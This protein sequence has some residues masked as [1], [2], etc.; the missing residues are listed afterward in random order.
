MFCPTCGSMIDDDAKFCPFCGQVMSG[1]GNPTVVNDD[2]SWGAPNPPADGTTEVTG[3]W[4]SNAAPAPTPAPVPVA[5]PA[6]APAPMPAP[7]PQQR[8]SSGWSNTPAPQPQPAP[9]SQRRASSTRS[10]SG[11]KKIIVGV[12]AALLVAALGTL[13]YFTFFTNAFLGKD[14]LVGHF[15]MTEKIGDNPYAHALVVDAEKNGEVKI[16]YRGSYFMGKLVRNGEFLDS[17]RYEVENPHFANGV[18]MDDVSITLVAPFGA[19]KGNKEGVWAIC[20]RK[21]KDDKKTVRSEVAVINENKTAYMEILKDKDLFEEGWTRPE[22][23]T[24][25]WSERSDGLCSFVVTGN[26]NIRDVDFPG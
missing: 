13:G 15:S 14:V 20:Y 16:L 22:N 25:T 2:P 3:V 8:T 6:P 26:G 5:A 21:G 12:V 7:Q 4:K 24:Q 11:Q 23:M 9:Q 17:A 19:S 1:P 18:A 10:G